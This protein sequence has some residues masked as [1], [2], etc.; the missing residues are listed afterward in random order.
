M[1]TIERVDL[2]IRS[3]GLNDRRF[4]VSA[5]LGNGILGKARKSKRG[6]L[7]ND[8]ID[9]ILNTY[10][11]LSEVWLKCGDGEMIN[12]ESTK[13]PACLSGWLFIS[14]RGADFP[15]R[16]YSAKWLVPL[17]TFGYLSSFYAHKLDNEWYV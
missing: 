8:I 6:N 5:N 7:S 11:D 4:E 1:K 16:C 15:D 9:K 14:P 13:Q 17:P 12:E 10:S 3:K 2:Y